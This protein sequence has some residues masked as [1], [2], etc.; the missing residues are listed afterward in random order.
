MRTWGQINF[1]LTKEFPGLDPELLIGYIGTAY[2]RI[3]DHLPWKGLESG[4]WLIVKGIHNAGSVALTKGLAAIAGTGTGW[5]SEVDGRKF[6]V[7]GQSTWYTFTY[8]SPTSGT[9]DRAYEG[10]DA[11]AAGYFIY[12]DTYYL[13]ANCKYVQRIE[14]SPGGLPLDRKTQDEL[15]LAFRTFYGAPLYWL[16]GEDTADVGLGVAHQ[17]ELY[18]IPEDDGSFWTVF[19]KAPVH[20]DGSNTQ[21]YPLSWVS[22]DAILAGAKKLAYRHAGPHQNVA[23]SES[24][25]RDFLVLL[26]QMAGVEAGRAEPVKLTPA[27]RYTRHRRERWQR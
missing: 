27:S 14:N 22:S 15:P 16:P 9:L 6:R 26:G 11:T 24:E 4:A 18:P 5:S 20:F 21:S 23:S 8:V 12:Q 17:V 7:A 13:P 2:R 1:E 3:L 25:E 19:Q 10:E